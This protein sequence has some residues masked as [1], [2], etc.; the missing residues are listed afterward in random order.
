MVKYVEEQKER[1]MNQRKELGD[2]VEKWEESEELQRDV[3]YWVG[4]RERNEENCIECW[5]LKMGS[6][7]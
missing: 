6:N 7:V 2:L 3:F 4:F 1:E 5:V